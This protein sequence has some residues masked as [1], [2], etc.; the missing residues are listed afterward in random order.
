MRVL[1]ELVPN[2][3]AAFVVLSAFIEWLFNKLQHLVP[4]VIE[5]FLYRFA[6][7]LIWHSHNMVIQ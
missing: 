6:S 4:R 1:W 3:N 7:S 5:S 2:G